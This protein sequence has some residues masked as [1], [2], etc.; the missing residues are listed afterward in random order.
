MKTLNQVQ[1]IG[2]LGKE[3]EIKIVSESSKVARFSLA[4]SEKF[5]N[6]E[7]DKVERTQ[8]HNIVIWGSLC[9][10]VEKFVHKGDLCYLNG[11]V[12]Y[13]S[14]DDSEG[15]KKYITEIVC[16]HL[17]ILKSNIER[18]SETVYKAN[19]TKEEPEVEEPSF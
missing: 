17:L 18:T 14:F 15:V 11:K 5:T 4:T 16:N 2:H 19:N 1:L 10:I 3:P 6:K 12:E 7:G 9:E 13:R 8:W